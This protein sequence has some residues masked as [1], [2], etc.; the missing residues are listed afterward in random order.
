MADSLRVKRGLK[1]NLPPL[2][3]GE[4]GFCTD[5]NQL[6]VGS[7]NGN[8]LIN[9]APPKNFT[10]KT[11][12]VFGDSIS[13]NAWQSPPIQWPA[14]I[15][16]NMPNITVNNY[17]VDGI[18]FQNMYE[19]LANIGGAG[20]YNV[21][22]LGTNNWNNGYPLGTVDDNTTGTL[23]GAMNLVFAALISKYPNAKNYVCSLIRRTKEV[24]C[25][26]DIRLINFMLFQ[27]SK[28][29][30]FCY[31]NL[32]DNAPGL[33]PS[34]AALKALNITDGLH[35]NPSYAPVLAETICSYILY[36]KADELSS[37]MMLAYGPPFEFGGTQVKPI[38]RISPDGKCSMYINAQIKT[39]DRA[40]IVYVF[41]DNFYSGVLINGIVSQR[42]NWVPPIT[43]T[44]IPYSY[45]GIIPSIGYIEDKTVRAILPRIDGTVAQDV[46]VQIDYYLYKAMYQYIPAPPI[47]FQTV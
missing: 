5:T 15:S 32:Y 7:T 22:F 3:T 28:K 30:G 44:T 25:A 21:L 14:Y 19:H 46:Y 38:L 24:P 41:T 39:T 33:N 20:D 6:Y 43:D 12:N 40:A 11:I 29:Y 35:P 26:Y 31:I 18:N 9:N 16:A 13:K 8:A 37:D 45:N 10:G 23:Y 27:M 47:S 4:I 42:G 34:N 17:S 1:A 2:M 36:N